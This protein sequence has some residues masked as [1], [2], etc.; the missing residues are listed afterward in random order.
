MLD[1]QYE[2]ARDPLVG[3]CDIDDVAANDAEE[4]R[5][6]GLGVHLDDALALY[7]DVAA[8]P[9]ASHERA[10]EACHQTYHQNVAKE[11]GKAAN[12]EEKVA[13]RIDAA[14]EGDGEVGEAGDAG[15]AAVS[16]V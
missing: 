11:K 12:D 15:D 1:A 6:D 14:E 3:E 16:H 5:N 8:V 7:L 2:V 9:H 10:T 13:D 4:D